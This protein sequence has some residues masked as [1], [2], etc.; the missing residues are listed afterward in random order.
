M[1]EQALKR[2]GWLGAAVIAAISFAD[3]LAVQLTVPAEGG[4]VLLP[5][6]LSKPAVVTI[7]YG[8]VLAL[9]LLSWLFL[10]KTLVQAARGARIIVLLAAVLLAARGILA[11]QGSGAPFDRARAARTVAK[12]RQVDER[13]Q[14]F[15]RVRG[16]FPTDLRELGL[17]RQELAD[18]WRHEL[19]FELLPGASGYRLWAEGAPVGRHGLEDYYPRLTIE[20]AG[21]SFP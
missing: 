20:R 10:Q 3:V 15:H 1:S 11:V 6:D 8:A 17:S 19:R 13:V 5:L 9:L 12:L 18:E 21:K 14:E 4:R 7:L 2:R 16:R